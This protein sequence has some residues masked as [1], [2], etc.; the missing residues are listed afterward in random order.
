MIIKTKGKQQG[1]HVHVSFFMGN[2]EESL[3][4]CGVL[5]FRVAEWKEFE[6]ALRVGTSMK[7]CPPELVFLN[8]VQM[9]LPF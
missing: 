6:G 5:T 3:G 8:N 7:G 4:K 2:D 9:E 1:A